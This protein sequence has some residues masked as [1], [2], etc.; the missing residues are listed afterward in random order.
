MRLLNDG[1]A[2]QKEYPK[3]HS[4]LGGYF[5]ESSHLCSAATGSVEAPDCD[6]KPV[7]DRRGRGSAVSGWVVAGAAG[8][9]TEAESSSFFAVVF[10]FAPSSPYS[11]GT[12]TKATAIIAINRAADLMLVPLSYAWLLR[13]EATDPRFASINPLQSLP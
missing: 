11:P 7:E 10:A 5:S 4:T 2:R 9:A 6:C 12:I 8:A 1:I 13:R 3:N